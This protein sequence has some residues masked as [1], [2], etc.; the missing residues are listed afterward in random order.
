[1]I[2]MFLQDSHGGDHFLDFPILPVSRTEFVE[3]E[4]K[5]SALPSQMNFQSINVVFE[6]RT[7]DR[8]LLVF[9]R[10]RAASLQGVASF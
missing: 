2:N 9:L 1:M 5:L 6:L 8:Q 7:G 10:N 4:N 3:I